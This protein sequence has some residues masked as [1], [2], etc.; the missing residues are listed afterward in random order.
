[1]QLT[2]FF[3]QVKD[4]LGKVTWPT[5]ESSLNMTGVVLLGSLAIGLYVG[6]LDLILTN[7][8]GLFFK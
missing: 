4:E 1:M 2:T 5:R 3:G 8:L 6:G 7:L